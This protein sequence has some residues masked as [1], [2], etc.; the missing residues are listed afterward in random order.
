MFVAAAILFLR[1]HVRS[2]DLF[3]EP[4][5]QLNIGGRTTISTTL[6]GI[7]SL[8][9]WAIILA[10]T[11]V[12]SQKLIDRNDPFIS[13]VDEALD[14]DNPPISDLEQSQFKFGF[15]MYFEFFEE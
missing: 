2:F 10:F 13:Q 12:R 14:I 4:V 9:I 7:I 8:G 3:S 6:G 15:M 1:R 11:F 5:A